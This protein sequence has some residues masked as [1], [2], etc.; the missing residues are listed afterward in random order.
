[1]QLLLVVTD[2]VIVSNNYEQECISFVLC[3]E[4]TLAIN[5]GLVRARLIDSVARDNAERFGEPK[6]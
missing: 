5:T 4:L 1:M 2:D 6:K 3:V